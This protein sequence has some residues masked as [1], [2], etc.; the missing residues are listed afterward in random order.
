ME[1]LSATYRIETPIDPADAAAVLAGEQSSGTFVAVPGETAE[2][3]TRFAARVESV[4]P[5]ESVAAGS[6]R[7]IH[8]Q[9]PQT[10]MKQAGIAA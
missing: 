7:F 4:T 6:F 2:L 3:R 8:S 9:I 10:S 5:L 1:R